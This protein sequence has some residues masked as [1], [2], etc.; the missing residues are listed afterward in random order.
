MKKH[1]GSLVMAAML[2]TMAWMTGCDSVKQEQLSQTSVAETTETTAETVVV[3]EA[4]TDVEETA[5]TGG[6]DMTQSKQTFDNYDAFLSEVAAHYPGVVM[7]APNQIVSG[8]W[9]IQRIDLMTSG[10]QPF[11]D[12]VLT[13]PEGQNLILTVSNEYQ[14]GSF[15]ALREVLTSNGVTAQSGYSG[16]NWLVGMDEYLG[17]YVLYGLT[18]DENTYYTLLGTNTEGTSL[19]PAELQALHD[20]MGL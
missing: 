3:S 4:Q 9:E 11:Y 1:M 15:D 16:N 5:P 14:F 13:T 2:L 17:A 18:G 20:T 6:L 12:Y 8:Q 19:E 7:V 10:T